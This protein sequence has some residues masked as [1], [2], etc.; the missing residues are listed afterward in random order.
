MTMHRDQDVVEHLT[1]LRAQLGE[2]DA[3][4]RLHARYNSRLLYYLR[5]LVT[6]AGLAEDILQEVWLTVVK[7]ITTL[8][9]PQAFRAWIYRIARHRAI[10]RARRG[11]R[12]LSLD[13]LPPAHEVD[14]ATV[15][16]ADDLIARFDPA[17]I[18]AALDRLSVAHRDVLTLRFLDELSYQEIAEVV[19]CGVGTVRSRLYYAKKSLSDHLT[20]RD[21]SGQKR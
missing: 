18:H 14:P 9:D 19:G 17:A 6:P 4:T 8:D 1:V 15:E 20:R 10:S 5:R 7:K 13:D 11:R 2:H 12:D 16:R 3:F 21:E